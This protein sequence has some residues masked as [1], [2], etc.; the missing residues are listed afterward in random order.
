[1]KKIKLNRFNIIII[2]VTFALLLFFVISYFNTYSDYVTRDASRISGDTVYINDLASDYYYYLGMNYVGDINSNT[3]NYQESDLKMVTIN[4]YGYPS[5]DNSLTGYVSLDE[6]QNKFVYYKYYPIKNNQISIE[7][8]DNPFTLRPVG[9]GF[10][11]WQSS[12]GTITKDNLTNTYTLTCSSNT[13]TIN[14][15]ANWVDANVVFLKGEDGDDNFDGTSD[16]YA[17]AS[18]SRAFELLRQRSSN[19]NDRELN[20]IV[21]TGDLDHSINYTRPVTH[22]WS[23]T[24]DYT[25]NETFTEGTEYL[26]EYKQGNNRYALNDNWSNVGTETLSTTVRPS[27]KSIWTITH[28][29]NGYLIKNKDSGNYLGH[30]QYYN[31][32]VAIFVNSTPAYWNYDTVLRTFYTTYPITITRYDLSLSSSINAGST[33]LIG[34]KNSFTQND[35]LESVTV[36]TDGLTSTT[37]DSEGYNETNN[38]RINNLGNGY[39]IYNVHENKYLNYYSV[40]NDTHL[41][42]SNNSVAWDYDSTN[43]TLG[44]LVTHNTLVTQYSTSTISAGSTFIGYQN[45]NNYMLLNA[46]MNFV[47]QN[48]NTLPNSNMEWDIISAGNN[49]FYLQNS[50][51]QYIRSSRGALSLTTNTNNRTAFTLNNNRLYVYQNGNYRYLYNNNGTLATS[52]NQNNATNL[53]KVSATE[54][55]TPTTQENMYLSFNNNS[56]TLSTT[57][58]EVGFVSYQRETINI[59]RN[60]NLRYDTNNN[61]F[62][63]SASTSGTPLSFAT[64]KENREMTNTNRGNMANNGNYSTNTNVA[65]TI[66]SM[67]DNIDYRDDVTLTLTNTSYFRTTAY[68]DLQLENLKVDSTGYQAINDSTTSTNLRNTYSSLVGNSNNVRIGRGMEPTSWDDDSSVVFAN[69]D[70]FSCTEHFQSSLFKFDAFFF[71]DNGSTCKDG[72]VFQHF[73]AA[74]TKAWSFNCANLELCTKTVNNKCCKCFAINIFRD[75]Q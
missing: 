63:F 54:V 39:T 23:Y 71:A 30:Q 25:D 21:L 33:Y 14:V 5:S 47:Q 12:N 53:Y 40:N 20:I 1:M 69:G 24:Y 59:N 45:G 74:V 17:V 13:D 26:I 52:T 32:N 48:T 22:T 46:N 2:C 50:N 64:F 16:Y 56:W 61:N 67:Y 41:E 7:L 49:T 60:F 66:T 34:D 8:I 75:N 68:N 72:D 15:Y 19:I 28:D 6:Q 73:F 43:N 42:L 3:V 10:G 62:A 27:D 29:E 58:S 31:D 70:A 44:T 55:Q 4:Y 38:W 11:G 18:W 51:G 36:L 9:K 65:V 35:D 57:G 37:V